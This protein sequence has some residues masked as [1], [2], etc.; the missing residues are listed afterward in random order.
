MIKGHYLIPDV[1]YVGYTIQDMWTDYN[2]RQ[3]INEVRR[4]EYIKLLQG[5]QKLINKCNKVV[6]KYF[7]RLINNTAYLPYTYK[8][9]ITKNEFKNIYIA[10]FEKEYNSKDKHVADIINNMYKIDYNT[11][12]CPIVT[13][14]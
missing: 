8:D 5:P 11:H 3:M 14:L 4:I 13:R 1:E 9:N 12:Y 7:K 6:N 10:T 2:N